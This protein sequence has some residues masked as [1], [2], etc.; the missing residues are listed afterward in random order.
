MQRK[1]SIG[2][3][4]VC[5]LT[6]TVWAQ[7][8]LLIHDPGQPI[9]LP[10][11]IW[12][13]PPH[14]VPPPLPPPRPVPPP[15]RPPPAS[16]QIRELDY[17][18]DIRDQ[19]AEVGISQTFVNPGSQ[20]L[21]VAFVFPVPPQAAIDRLTFLVDGKELEAQLLDARKARSIYE[22]YV[23]RCQDPALL[24]WVGY[25]MLRTSVFPLPPNGQRTVLLRFSQLLPRERSLTELLLPLAAARYTATPVERLS[26]RV[27]LATTTPLK[28]IY[29]P[30]HP[31]QID[32]RDAQHA[33]VRFEAQQ[34]IPA[35]D[36]RLFFDTAETPLGASLL[37]SRP[38]PQEDGYFLLLVTPP[39][40]G[41]QAARLSKTVVL[42]VDRS[43]SMAGK[44][45]EQAKESLL[46][47]LNHLQP[48]DTFNIVAYDSQVELFRPELQRADAATLQ[49]ARGFVEGLHAGG[50][51]HID[52]ALISA[53]RLIPDGS[54]PSFLVFLTDG[55]PTVGERSELRIA[56]NARQH[57]RSRT[58]L[59]T[60]GV[61][62]DVN[63]RLLDRL[64]R[65]NF[66][67]TV[68][69]RPDE[70]LEE[71]VSR[72]YSKLADPV[73]SDVTLSLEVAGAPGGNIQR[74]YPAQ[75]HDLFAG[76]QLVV[77]G[78]YRQGGEVQGVLTGQVGGQ[79]QR[80]EFAGSLVSHSPDS[81]RAFVEKLWALRRIGQIIDEIDLHG[82]NEELVSEL[83]RLSR[84]HGIL[85]PYT[86][87]LADET[88][89]PRELADGRRQVEAAGRALRTLDE[90]AGAPGFFQRAE[91][92]QLQ[93]A[94][95]A[96]AP[97][98]TAPASR[99][100]AVLG[101]VPGPG[102]PGLHDSQTDRPQ[103]AK[104]VQQVGRETLYKRG[105]L[106]IA[107]NALDVDLEKD[108][109]KIQRIRR[110][111][112]E[113]FALVRANTPD[114]NAVL[115]AQEE[116]TALLVRLRAQVYWIE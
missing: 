59:I 85:T 50:G 81:S 16:Y 67:Q 21:E 90:A 114:E 57:N 48:E 91:K 25:G 61:G 40:A 116:G 88:G 3:L 73:L 111:S 4:F 79:T 99:P 39:L 105:T 9:P 5:L 36:F 44:K 28:N 32:R 80:F 18:I 33:V 115:A 13:P 26:I 97:T 45:M 52:A 76:E 78:R 20:P 47:V 72:L 103:S 8:V 7:G 77:V 22:D 60:L 101:G 62:Y 110:F 95:Q 41:Q 14:P 69:V 82:Q 92:V 84:Q 68:Y 24:E 86:S 93:N 31:V 106:W 109:A 38:N 107:A 83:V 65:E 43:G 1:S 87:F 11:P 113:Y 30:T 23:R 34:S 66:G 94:M 37:S 108:A 35:S 53:L 102:S 100:E 70:N 10:R 42:V 98:S 74:M 27:A 58:R 15:R 46:F 6:Q 75:I 54:Q 29:S 112:D 17:Q 19:I 12:P 71:H 56:A 2:M 64:A 55:Q 63:S 104:A 89:S 49:A 51:T 96:A